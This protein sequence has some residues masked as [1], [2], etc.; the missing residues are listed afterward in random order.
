VNSL[1]SLPSD[2]VKP[3]TFVSNNFEDL[4]FLPRSLPFYWADS[5]LSSQ[6]IDIIFNFLAAKPYHDAKSY[7]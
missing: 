1:F 2:R 7:R 4:G 3:M 6:P 5:V